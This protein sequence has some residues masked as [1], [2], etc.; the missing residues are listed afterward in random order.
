M[1]TKACD[2]GFSFFEPQWG[3]KSSKR[4]RAYDAMNESFGHFV[5]NL[6]CGCFFSSRT[7]VL[8]WCCGNVAAMAKSCT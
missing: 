3:Q 6:T 4:A 1:A 2:H 7:M 8:I 5:W